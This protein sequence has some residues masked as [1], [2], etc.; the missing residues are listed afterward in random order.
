MNKPELK[1]IVSVLNKAK[2]GL[3]KTLGSFKAFGRKMETSARRTGK[4]IALGFAGIGASITGAFV[5][6]GVY[7]KRTISMITK[8]GDDFGKMSKRMGISSKE[9]QQTMYAL[10]LG[11]AKIED[12]EKAYKK[13]ALFVLDANKGLTTATDTLDDLNISVKELQGLTPDQTFWKLSEAIAGVEDPLKRAALAQKVFGRTGTAMLPMLAEGVEKM[14][15]MRQ[16]AIDLGAVMSEEDIANAEALTDSIFRM[17]LAFKGFKITVFAGLLP[18]I[19]RVTDAVV[20]FWKEMNKSGI[21]DKLRDK[22][23]KM[24]NAIVDKFAPLKDILKDAF[25]GE[26]GAFSKGLDLMKSK[27]GEIAKYFGQKIGEA[28]VE[29]VKYAAKESA[30]ELFKVKVSD[31]K[32]D[33]KILNYYNRKRETDTKRYGVVKAEKN[34]QENMAKFDKRISDR[35]AKKA[36]AIKIDKEATLRVAKINQGLYKFGKSA[37]GFDQPSLPAGV[38]QNGTPQAQALNLAKKNA[39][40]NQ[41]SAEANTSVNENLTAN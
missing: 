21:A 5:G 39:E 17:K 23:T 2:T 26:D 4:G 41:K 33:N 11:G 34:Y 8:L 20:E 36:K 7:L 29:G 28:I 30:K 3:T 24:A 38:I 12:L 27:M 40:A 6:V 1:I 18:V 14:K 25:S 15:A 32:A 9:I 19:Q 35:E 16:E 22:I 31:S 10:Q 37:L 13:L